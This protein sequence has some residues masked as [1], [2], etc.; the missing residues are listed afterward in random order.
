MRRL[1]RIDRWLYMAE[2]GT[3][4]G[5]FMV[6]IIAVIGNIVS[7]NLFGVSFPIILEWTPALVL[8]LSLLGASLALRNGRHIKLELVLRYCPA[9]WRRSAARVSAVFGAIV[10]AVLLLV[11]FDFL[12]NELA[13]FGAGGITAV[14]FPLFFGLCLLRYFLALIGDPG[15]TAPGDSGINGAG[16]RQGGVVESA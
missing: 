11:S 9:G 8:W 3:V 15:R 13:L 1:Q 5:L 2:R 10:M 16:R 14:I 12:R 6:L 4:V 7:R